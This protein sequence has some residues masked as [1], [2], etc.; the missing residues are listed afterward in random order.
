MSDEHVDDNEE[1]AEPSF[2]DLL[3]AYEKG[4]A[5]DV[6]VG[7]KIRGKIIAIGNDTIYIDTGSKTDGVAEIK[8]FLGDDGELTVDTGD[9]VELFV[10]RMTESEVGLSRAMGGDG[11]FHQLQDAFENQ[12]PVLGNVK[13]TCKG[14]LRVEIMHR[15]AFCPISQIDIQYAEDPE[16]FVGETFEFAITRLEEKGRNIVVSRRVLLAKAMEAAQEAF[17]NSAAV[18]NVLDGRVSRL[19][20]YG[21]FVHLAEGVEGLV[22]ISELSWS[23]LDTPE[24]A[25]ATGD[26]I[27]V[28]ILG[29]DTDDKGRRRIRLSARAVQEDPWSSASTRFVEGQKVT[30]TVTRIADFGVFVEIAPGIEG[31]VHISEMSYTRRVIHPG[32]MVAVGDSV[33]VMVQRVEQERRRISL[34]MKD[35]EGDPWADVSD[36]FKSGQLVEGTVAR[37]ER[38]G[39][40][41]E[42]SPGVTGLLPKSNMERAPNPAALENMSPGTRIRLRVD[43]VDPAA[44]RISLSPED[45]GAE[46][47][48]EDY[49]PGASD[50]PAMS[51]LAEKLRQALQKGKS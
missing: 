48:W 45:G 31:L 34:S 20:P 11:E 2:A 10:V 21:A 47:G 46:S 19:M 26:P 40:F 9:T 35:A 15:L 38:F 43:R 1:A 22:H 37:K 8:E 41:V 25:V 18:G 36:N 27:R 5:D 30:G 12:I 6:R 24:A 42:L 7:D 16:V 44:R 3:D 32:D 23:R 14:G 51:D 39:I 49:A 17:F 33:S 13:E 50:T 29:I 28:K 4:M